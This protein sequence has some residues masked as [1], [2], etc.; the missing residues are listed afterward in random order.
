MMGYFPRFTL[1]NTIAAL[2]G[3]MLFPL[4]VLITP[5]LLEA[6]ELG[7][8]RLRPIVVDWKVT[9]S[10]IEGDDVI[11]S[12]SMIKQRDGLFVPPTLARDL[13]TGR[14]YPVMS[15]APT[16]GRTWAASNNPQ[17]WGPWT[18]KGGANKELLFI[19][20]YMS[21][22]YRPSAVELGVYKPAKS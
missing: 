18:V 20:I 10:H 21:D 19:N 1:G 22:G 16:A 3:A 2:I 11:L 13:H 7:Y 4:F 6:G 5:A 8:D 15:S 12:G 17:S 9:E 14:N